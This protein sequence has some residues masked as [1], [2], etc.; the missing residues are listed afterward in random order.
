MG[1]PRWR[2]LRPGCSIDAGWRLLGC[3]GARCTGK[4]LSSVVLGHVGETVDSVAPE[5]VRIKIRRRRERGCVL[6]RNASLLAELNREFVEA[7]LELV[8]HHL[9]KDE[10]A[11]RINRLIRI[12]DDTDVATDEI[13]GIADT[14]LGLARVL[15]GKFHFCLNTG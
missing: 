1:G 13:V 4:T 7:N 11:A 5:R 8:S 10:V 15:E 6:N 3:T 2:I 14:H 12:G 9:T